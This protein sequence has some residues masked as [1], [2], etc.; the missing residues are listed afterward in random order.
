MQYYSIAYVA[1]CQPECGEY[2]YMSLNISL[3]SICG[4]HLVI[5]TK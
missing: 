5:L 1:L 4:G 2:V 3:V